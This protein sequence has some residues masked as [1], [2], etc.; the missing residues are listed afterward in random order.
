MPTLSSLRPFLLLGYV[1]AVDFA[2][3]GVELSREGAYYVSLIGSIFLPYL[4]SDTVKPLYPFP[5]HIRVF[6][7]L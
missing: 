6:K 7:L 3:A 1:F 2:F 4:M 5:S